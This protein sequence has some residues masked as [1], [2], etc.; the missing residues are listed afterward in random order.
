MFL[1]KYKKNKKEYHDILDLENN[2]IDKL[3]YYWL[4]KYE[5][6]GKIKD[7]QVNLF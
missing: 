2:L 4:L 5:K 1:I 7:L 6:K 3:K